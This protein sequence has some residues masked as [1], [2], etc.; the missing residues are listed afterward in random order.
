LRPSAGAAA[1]SV[2]GADVGIAPLSATQRFFFTTYGP[3]AHFNQAILLR[4]R[5]PVTLG[6]LR[7]ACATLVAR[8]GM[9]RAR[10]LQ[11]DGEWQQEVL[12]AAAVAPLVLALDLCASPDAD[13]ELQAHATHMQ[14][15][16][17]LERAPLWSAVLYDLPEGQRLL[18][19][20]HHLIVDGVSW[21][22]L[23]EDLE[24]ALNAQPLPPR[25]APYAVWVDCQHRYAAAGLAAE[26]SY[27]PPAAHFPTATDGGDRHVDRRAARVALSADVTR[28]LL[29]DAHK[30][31]ATEINDLLI[32]AVAAAWRAWTGEA[33]CAL[34]L[35]G[36]G[37]EPLGDELDVARTVG[38]FTSIFPVAFE[39]PPHTDVGATIKHVKETL[40]AIPNRGAGYGILRFL[41]KPRVELAPL[42]PLAFNYL[43]RFDTG[44]DGWFVP[45]PEP[46][47]A[48]ASPELALPWLE[49]TA[50]VVGDEMDLV[51]AYSARRYDERAARA[52][53]DHVRAELERVVEHTVQ[54]ENVELT[55]SDFDYPDFTQESLDNFL[56]AL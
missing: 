15:G 39:L 18:L 16:F 38:W 36:H 21:R 28:A 32:A 27:W 14:R 1:D 33:R 46:G 47:P 22:V 19:S 12:A 55:A 35:E 48:T 42:P 2:D 40:R 49:L 26:R 53:L 11:R 41:A 37:R 25:S 13:D 9:L 56:R 34:T 17:A 6:A 45:A 44:G 29:T 43:G 52:F 8:H 51:L 4:A 31:Y 5:R 3:S 50:A 7:T 30:A 10:F 24:R 54:R 23:V 20:A